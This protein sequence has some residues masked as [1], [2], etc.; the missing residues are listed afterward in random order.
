MKDYLVFDLETQYSAQEVGGWEHIAEMKMSLGVIWDSRKSDYAVYLEDNVADLIMHLQSGPLVIGYNHIGF[1]Y[2]VLSG[3]YPLSE[4]SSFREKMAKLNNLD[5][6]LNIKERLGFRLKLDN[7]AKATLGVGKSADGLQ[8]LEWYKSGQIDLISEYC[9]QDVAVT[10]DLF[11]YGLQHSIVYYDSG[12][13][14][15]KKVAVDWN[16]PP[17]E[18]KNQSEQLSF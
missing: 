18:K 12:K 15:I 10:R 2:R 6:L 8:A 11:I 3:Y 9:K 4:R 7:L 5:M 17:E 14:G 1:D 16:G 13:E